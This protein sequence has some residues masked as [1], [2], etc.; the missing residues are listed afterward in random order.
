MEENIEPTHIANMPM[1][2][3]GKIW[4]AN[5]PM[6]FLVICF[7]LMVGKIYDL[8]NQLDKLESEVE[9][10]SALAENANRYA[11]SHYSDARLK[12]NW[13]PIVNPLDRLLQI[14]GG[15]YNWNL[16]GQE[17]LNAN[18]ESQ[19]GF[20]AQEVERLFPELVFEDQFGYK[21]IDYSRFTVVL[22]EAIR[23]QQGEILS[24][25]EKLD[26]ICKEQ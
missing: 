21:Q 12:T 8:Q 24:I 17:Y 25:E 26:M 18:H 23:E 9:Y 5:W 10:V 15:T 11:H 6:I 22:L 14:N 4:R 1:K 7:A 2:R 19:I 13:E 20:L 3:G 16:M